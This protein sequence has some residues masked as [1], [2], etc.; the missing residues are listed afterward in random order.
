MHAVEQGH[1]S[2]KWST[3]GENC[4]KVL[5]QCLAGCDKCANCGFMVI[6]SM[7][8]TVNNLLRLHN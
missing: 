8:S 6:S 1:P 5:G 3:S 2:G 7:G 4:R